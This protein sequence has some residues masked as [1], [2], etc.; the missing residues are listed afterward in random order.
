MIRYAHIVIISAS[1]ILLFCYPSY[2][3]N[4]I[5]HFEQ[6][7]TEKGLSNKSVY[8]I[9]SDSKGFLWIGTSDGLNRYDGYKFTVFKNIPGDTNTLSD[10]VIYNIYEDEKEQLWICTGNGLNKFDNK[11]NTF[12][13]FKHDRNSENSI[14]GN[15]VYK[16]Y[17]DHES[18]YWIGT[19]NG[20]LN[21]YDESIE[22]FSHYIYDST[23]ASREDLLPLR[24]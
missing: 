6:L 13:R 4:E 22:T 20:G 10:N 1:L 7:N 15:P 23:N 8:A 12:Q 2:T 5:M 3:Q 18:I 17:Q 19:F 9:L 21:R 16:I 14:W 11:R 24:R